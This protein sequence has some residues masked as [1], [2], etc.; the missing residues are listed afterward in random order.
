[1]AAVTLATYHDSYSSAVQNA[2]EY[3]ESKGYMVDEQDW[4]MRVSTGQG[5]PDVG[6]YSQSYG[7]GLIVEK[8]G[9]EAKKCLHISVYGLNNGY[10]LTAYIM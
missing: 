10:E 2:R 6:E 9:N 4:F 3:A 7:I 5:R 1:M 8:T